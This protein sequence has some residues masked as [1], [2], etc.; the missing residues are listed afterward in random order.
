MA[1]REV[2][3]ISLFPWEINQAYLPP[4]NFIGVLN[5]LGLTTFLKWG[6]GQERVCDRY[7]LKCINAFKYAFVRRLPCGPY[8]VCSLFNVLYIL[9]LF[10]H[11]H[12]S[13]WYLS[14]KDFVFDRKWGTGPAS[15][16]QHSP[17]TL[18]CKLATQV[19]FGA[20]G[21]GQVVLQLI[22]WLS[23]ATPMQRYRSVGWLMTLWHGNASGITGPLWGDSDDYWWI[24]LAN[25]QHLMFLLLLA[26]TR[27]WSSGWVAG[28]F[29][30]R[31]GNV[32]LGCTR[33]I[34]HHRFG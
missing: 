11:M 14:N 29:A 23:D 34:G 21:L 8:C 12:M 28:D 33:G 26:E 7:E 24:S 4:L 1:Y 2:I 13:L 20:V 30:W 9:L 5:K 18:V 19:E 31:H 27:C 15:V 3:T 22:N 25:R 6:D 32:I 17:R 16:S 10:V